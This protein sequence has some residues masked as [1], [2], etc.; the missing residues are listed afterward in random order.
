MLVFIFLGF[1]AAII[2]NTLVNWVFYDLLIQIESR[3][4]QIDWSKDGFPIGMFHIPPDSTLFKGTLS[5]NRVLTKWIFKKPD[6]IWKDESAKTFYRF[7]R[8]TGL[9]QFSLILLFALSFIVI[10]FSQP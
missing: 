5:R 3:K 2:I 8:I 9:V 6:W 7:F 10:F 4:F 1:L